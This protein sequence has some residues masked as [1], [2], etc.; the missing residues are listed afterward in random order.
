MTTRTRTDAPAVPPPTA[1]TRWWTERAG[2]LA[3]AG[4]ALYGVLALGWSLTGRGYPFGPNDPVGESSLLRMLPADVGAPV[5]AAVAL[6]TAVVAFAMA[7]ESAVR[8][9]GVR[10]LL[11]LA[12]AW[13]IVAVLL[14]VVPDV[15]VLA[16]AGYAPILILNIPFGWL[17]VDYAE[18]FN[19]PLINKCAAVVGGLL[20]VRTVLTWQLRTGGGCVSCGRKATDAAGISAE[21][22]ARWGRWAAWTAALIPVIYAATRFAWLAGI[23]LGIS[24]E[25]LQDMQGTG[26]VWSG[27][28]LAAFGVVGGVLT[29]GLTQRWGE[30]FPRWMV[31]LAGRRVPVMLAVVPAT[32]VAFAVA[33]A[34]IGFVS[35]P[36][37]WGLLVES[38]GGFAP[39]L[40][41]PVWAVALGAA[42]LAYYLRRRGACARC[43][44]PSR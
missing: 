12:Y 25:M 14:V 40:L 39:I 15:T 27:A 13:T 33:A 19:W 16:F 11:L 26:Q 32:F 17:E 20:L 1:R 31:G 5:I 22:A 7:G 21:S 9:T 10:R 4:L 43:S 8:P 37:F 36:Q 23:P 28:G 44:P 34:G 18:L 24:T 38:P 6:I 29:L 3:A 35:S 30:I 2:Y 41:W 42:T